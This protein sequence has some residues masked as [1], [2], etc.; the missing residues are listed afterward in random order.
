VLACSPECLPDGLD[1]LPVCAL[2]V[3]LSFSTMVRLSK[4][5]VTLET[6]GRGAAAEGDQEV[7]WQLS[8]LVI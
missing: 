4:E 1:Y 5:V 2:V 6:A 7:V 8:V 3:A